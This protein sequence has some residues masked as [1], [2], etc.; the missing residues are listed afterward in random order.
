M[1]RSASTAS[2]GS[3]ISARG[4]RSRHPRDTVADPGKSAAMAPDK[5]FD[6][7]TLES[8]LEAL[9]QRAYAEGKTIEIAVYGGSALMLTYDWRLATKDVDAVFEADKQTVRRLAQ[10][11]AEENGWDPDWLNDGVKGF[12]SIADQHPDAKRLFRTF[13]SE[14]EPGLRVMVANPAYIFAM[15]CRAMRIGGVDD[16]TDVDDIK[17]L[18]RE[19]RLTN[20][21]DALDLVA[22]FYPDRVIEP[23]TRFGLEEIF[24]R[25]DTSDW[26]GN[27]S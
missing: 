17:Q 15:K 18:A 21:Q 11:I 14:A 13:P 26:A 22:S 7:A 9:G 19:L 20:A 10:Q 1:P 12:L 6:R 25:L 5:P 16:T 4:C 3:P 23:K 24:S 8:A 27:S 2:C